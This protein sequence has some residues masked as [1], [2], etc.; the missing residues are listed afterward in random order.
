MNNKQNLVAQLVKPV[1]SAVDADHAK[2]TGKLWAK[3]HAGTTSPTG[4]PH[5]SVCDADGAMR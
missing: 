3:Y 1:V 4:A 2:F 5:G